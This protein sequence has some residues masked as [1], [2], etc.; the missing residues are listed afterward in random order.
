MCVL[1]E[2]VCVYINKRSIDI[3]RASTRAVLQSHTTQL[4]CEW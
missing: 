3:V 2:C 4:I 1:C